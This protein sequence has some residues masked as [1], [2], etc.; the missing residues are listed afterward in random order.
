MTKKARLACAV[1]AAAALVALVFCLVGRGRAPVPKRGLRSILA[2]IEGESSRRGDQAAIESQLSVGYANLDVRKGVTITAN[3]AGRKQRI[4]IK[5]IQ[6]VQCVRLD[7]L[8]PYN[9]YTF[10]ANADG[11]YYI[12]AGTLVKADFLAGEAAAITG[13]Y[14]ANVRQEAVEA[15]VYSEELC[16][17]KKIELIKITKRARKGA[18]SGAEAPALLRS[19][20]A[21]GS[22]GLGARPSRRPVATVY[23]LD[24]ALQQL[25][26]KFQIDENEAVVGPVLTYQCNRFDGLPNRWFDVPPVK[27]ICVARTMADFKTIMERLHH[28]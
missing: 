12:V 27:S 24:A 17:V 13:G 21:S 20:G 10:L 25:V 16:T 18:M 4:L 9:R 11:Y 26:A 2:S 5:V 19:G 22:Q 7:N 1:A 28:T 14:L 3:G 23:F 15:A 8:D 6:G